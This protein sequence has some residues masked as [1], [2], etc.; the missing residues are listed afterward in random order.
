MVAMIVND[1]EIN[2]ETSRIRAALVNA[3]HYTIPQA[4]K[5]LAESRLA[6]ILADE[7]AGTPAG[8]AAFLT[9]TVTGA[10]CFGET[11]AHGQL[12]RPLLLPVPLRVS[13][14]A[15]AARV[16]GAR[17]IPTPIANR[18]VFIGASIKRVNSWSVQAYWNGW[19]AGVTP[20][21]DPIRVGRSDCV[22][23]G[24]AAGSLAVGQAFLAEQGDLRAGKSAQGLSLWSP[25]LGE[26]GFNTP[27]PDQF[28][29][30]LDFWL[31]GLG[32]LG[33]AYL[34]SL[35]ILPFP[36]PDRVLLF[37]QDDDLVQKENWGTSILVKRGHY[38]D[39]KTRIAEEWVVA[40]G[41]RARRLDRRLDDTLRRTD[42]EPAIALAGLDRM[43]A[44]R[45]LGLPSFDYIIDAGLGAT[46]TEY[47]KF[48]INV[49][50][51]I[52]N[53]ARHFE[54]VEDQIS[55]RVATLLQLPAYQDL[56]RSHIK[57][58]C[59]AAMLA[60]HSVAVPF[61]SAFVGALAITQAIRIAS[62]QPH[63]SALTGDLGDLRGVRAA[64]GQPPKRPLFET[65]LAAS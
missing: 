26:N 48:R 4:D 9:A 7:A 18:C 22:L 50:D 41:F 39:L 60:E 59:G 11:T 31:I 65:I 62:G 34:W 35:S 17:V 32:N 64:L 20:G 56:A 37:L 5:K 58:P 6:I 2:S 52:E 12:D 15:D 61:V 23:A 1:V 16:L 46:A 47:Q 3:G 53:P 63:Y 44:R 57:G 10:R 29:F 30:P 14:L 13:S 55:Q 49:F 27:G 42:H 21:R 38:G 36:Q 45:L 25:D 28:Y 24:V 40:R 54:G 33:Q 43:P 19:S 51:S 8:Q